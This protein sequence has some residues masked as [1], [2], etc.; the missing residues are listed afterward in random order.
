M[1]VTG[2][3]VFP[4][5]KTCCAVDFENCKT[6]PWQSF[7]TGGHVFQKPKTKTNGSK[8]KT[9]TEN[10]TKTYPCQSFGTEEYLSKQRTF[11]WQ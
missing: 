11:T 6:C 8:T 1:T 10:I 9:K 7:G 2:W 4:Y 5:L 3:R